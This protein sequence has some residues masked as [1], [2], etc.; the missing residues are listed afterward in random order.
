[1]LHVG[2]V[3][4]EASGD[5]LGAGLVHALNASV[6]DLKIEGIGGQRLKDAGM[7]I[8]YPMEK[9][10]VMGITEVLG[11]YLELSDIRNEI[12]QY[13]IKNKPDVFI[14]IDAPD[15]NLQLEQA[16]RKHGITTVH[17][18]SPSVWAWRKYRIKKIR[19]AVDLI[20]NLFPF[21]SEF[22]NEYNIPNCFVGHPLADSLPTHPDTGGARKELGLS[23]EKKVIALLPGSRANEI[24]KITKPLLLAAELLNKTHHD[25]Q[26]ISGFIDEKSGNQFKRIHD[27]LTPGLKVGLFIGKT[28]RVIESADIVLLASGT[29]ALEA[30]ILKKPMVVT[31]KL[32]WATYFIVKFLLNIS[33]VSLPNIL[34]GKELVPE[35]LQTNC[36]PRKLAIEVNKLLDDSE[37]KI[38]ELRS[39][40]SELSDQLRKNAGHRAANAVLELVRQTEHA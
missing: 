35:C 30:M 6:T 10:S 23:S 8:L 28:H 9:L 29:V 1:M 19:D 17:Y 16:L 12:K 27:K 14:G 13:F 37:Q 36:T 31:Y 22:Y 34:A 20:L 40:F 7:N 33:H 11:R 25:L 2:I 4:G 39:C 15:F 24:N 26:F 5:T 32:S 3:A 38:S 18:V 21:E